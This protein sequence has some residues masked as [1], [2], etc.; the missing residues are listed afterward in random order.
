MDEL[1]KALPEGWN[2]RIEQDLEYI[3][4]GK[5]MGIVIRQELV[6]IVNQLQS[7][8]KDMFMNMPYKL[9]SILRKITI[10]LTTQS[11]TFWIWK[12]LYYDCLSFV[13]KKE[14]ISGY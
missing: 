5:T 1:K 7:G 8:V 4:K 2:T 10:C 11:W 9:L 13:G 3:G 12:K 6:D 14:W